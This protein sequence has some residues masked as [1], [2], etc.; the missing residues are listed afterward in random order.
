MKHIKPLLL[1]TS[2]IALVSCSG[3]QVTESSISKEDSSIEITTSI[4]GTTSE[5]ITSSEVIS[6]II[7][8]EQSS[9]VSSNEDISSSEALLSS[10]SEISS[11]SATPISS[12]EPISSSTPSVDDK[13]LTVNLYNPTCGSMSTE[14]LNDRLT[15]YINSLGDSSLV[16]SIT[17]NKCQITNDIPNKGDKVLQIGS[18]SETGLLVINFSKAIKRVNITAQTYHKPYVNTWSSSEAIIVPN[19]DNNSSLTINEEGASKTVDLSP[20][21]EQPKQLTYSF[22]LNNNKLSLAT[23]NADKG[24]VF[25][26]SM[27]LVY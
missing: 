20:E 24:R 19:V 26:K 21:N 23:E 3:R 12:E 1:L 17:N 15:T 11:S 27:T 7:S 2:L 8:S 14:V 22:N 13:S 9:I 25:I 5:I 16:A 4:V 10:I 6:S 18:S